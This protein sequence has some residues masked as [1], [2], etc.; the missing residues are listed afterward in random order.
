MKNW[1]LQLQAAILVNSATVF[2][3]PAPYS[4]HLNQINLMLKN[5][6]EQ[7]E[8]RFYLTAKLNGSVYELLVYFT[9][10]HRTLL[11]HS[12]VSC[13]KRLRCTGSLYSKP[14]C[15]KPFST[16]CLASTPSGISTVLLPS[17]PCNSYR[18]HSDSM[19]GQDSSLLKASRN[20]I[21]S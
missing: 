13:L 17:A 6:W 21:S 20:H 8:L 16:L 18:C 5:H 3:L 19:A 15:P 9:G 14:W 2:S 11:C 1:R 10:I 12:V 7:E 4:F